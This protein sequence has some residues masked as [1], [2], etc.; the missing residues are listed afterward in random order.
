MRR[1]VVSAP[2]HVHMGNP[3]LDG[4]YGRLYGTLGLA[5]E[6]PRV[7]VEASEGRGCECKRGDALEAYSKIVS[8]YDC[9]ARVRVVRE[10]PPHVGLGSTTTLFLSIARAVHEICRPG[11]PFEAADWAVRLGRST[12]SGLGL[13]SFLY[14]GLLFDAGFKPGE[15]RPPPLLFRAEPPGWMRIIVALPSRPIARIRELKKREDEILSSMPHMNPDMAD[16]LSRMML[17][18]ILGNIADGDWKLAGKFITEFNRSLGEYWRGPQESVYCCKESESLI[19]FFDSKGAI[20]VGQSSWGPTVY[21]A[22]PE[23][24]VG[25]VVVEARSLMED[26]GGGDVWITSPASTGALVRI[27]W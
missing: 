12:I 18:G 6:T 17:M 27:E 4:S 2:S 16:R 22:F 23:D 14:G 13:Y 11:L 24:L 8:A 7:I 26:L 21:A 3:D 10:I 20:F 5:L 1:V 25:R 19:R 9:S 15:S